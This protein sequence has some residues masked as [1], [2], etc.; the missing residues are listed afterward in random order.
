MKKLFF[1]GK[2]S[3][4]LECLNM[5]N[6]VYTALGEIVAL[7]AECHIN[8]FMPSGLF[9]PYILDES[10]YHLRRVWFILF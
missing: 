4:E 7:S 5:Y 2:N 10:I 1:S 3:N 8:P 9:Y 6:S